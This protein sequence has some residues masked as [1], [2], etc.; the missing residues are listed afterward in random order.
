MAGEAIEAVSQGVNTLVAELRGNPFALETVYLSVITFSREAQKVAPLTE[1]LHFQPP[2]LSVRPGTALGG[3]LRLLMQCLRSDVVKTTET[4]KGDYNP[5]VFLLTDGQPTDEWETAADTIQAQQNPKIANIYAIG[6]GPD[7]DV[8]VLYV[9][10]DNVFMMNDL[11]PEAFG[12]LFVWLSASVQTASRRLELDQGTPTIDLRAAPTDIL[13]VAPRFMGRR[14]QMPR[15]VFLHARCSETKQPYLMRFALRPHDRRYDVVA[16]HPLEVLEDGDADLLP[17]INSSLL[18]GCPSCP[19]CGAPGAGM[20][21]CG[22]LFCISPETQGPVTCPSCG[23][24]LAVGG[25]VGSFEV[26]RSQG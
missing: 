16:A 17:P 15:Q 22:A 3:A 8:G 19:Y 24:Q 1:I 7:V 25:D 18:N 13:E 9:I 10:T 23:A 26:K 6:C 11:S 21:P 12:K 4:T 14:D 2:K 20:C 5:L